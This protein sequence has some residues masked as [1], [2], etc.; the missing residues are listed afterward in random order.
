MST[1]DTVVR[2]LSASGYEVILATGK[3]CF[4]DASVLGFVADFESVAQLLDGWKEEE[5][6]FLRE[7]ASALRRDRRKAWNVYSI[8]LT[9]ERASAKQGRALVTLE[10][11]FQA[12]RKI[13]RS[14]IVTDRDIENA[15]GVLFPIRHRVSLR[16]E[17]TLELV[18]SRLSALPSG[19]VRSILAGGSGEDFADAL[20]RA[21]ESE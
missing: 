4:E 13:A 11:N 7:H 18:A 5:D 8:L 1:L 10:E 21:E 14:S 16:S 3:V 20:V 9:P 6:A 12:T 15:L 19:A 2:R 17:N